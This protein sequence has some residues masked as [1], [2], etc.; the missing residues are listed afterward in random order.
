MFGR[1]ILGEDWIPQE[2]LSLFPSNIFL[3]VLSVC[4]N[5]SSLSKNI[6][7]NFLS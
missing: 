5:L 3:F 1:L 4:Q 2:E 6:S 7:H